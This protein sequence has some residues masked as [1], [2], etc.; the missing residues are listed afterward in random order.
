MGMKQFSRREFLGASVLLGTA[1]SALSSCGLVGETETPS[2]ESATA[3]SAEVASFDISAGLIPRLMVGLN[4]VEG[5]VLTGGTVSFRL[6]LVGLAGGE[7]AESSQWSSAVPATYLPIPGRPASTSTKVALGPPSDGVGVYSTG[8]VTIPAA[9]FWEVEINAGRLGIALSGF[10][11]FEKPKAV[12]VGQKA[13][14]TKNPTV[15]TSG[16]TPGQLDSSVE[17]EADLDTLP[18]P[19]LHQ[20]QI[21]E[22]IA[23]G[24][25]VVVV[26]V[27]PAYCMS[28]FCGPLR[29]EVAKL[30]V[31]RSA[32]A[33]FI[34]LE[35]YA[36]ERRKIS[37]YAS[38]WIASKEDPNDANEPWL[39][40]IDKSG[41]VSH[42][43]DNVVSM[44]ELNAAL[45]QL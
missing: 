34:H 36:D 42:R 35:V 40:L 3:L 1:A 43:W 11:A 21:A 38:E 7:P 25:P 29:D 30:A 20:H 19:E 27:T 8:P 9:G 5:N 24:R 18:Y 33:D 6:R 32:D 45:D 15:R 31:G 13:P 10:E 12:S 22:S 16:V 37:P 4:D 14:V 28:K 39:F 26:V 44:T 2:M 17:G 23:K 41:T